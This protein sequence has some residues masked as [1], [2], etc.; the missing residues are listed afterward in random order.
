MLRITNVKNGANAVVL[1][2]GPYV[3]WVRWNKP[4]QSLEEYR[5]EL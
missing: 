2:G 3:V 1:P 4:T 5:Q